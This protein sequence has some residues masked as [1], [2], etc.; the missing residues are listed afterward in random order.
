MTLKNLFNTLPILQQVQVYKEFYNKFNYLQ[1][2]ETKSV[3]KG[4]VTNFK[5]IVNFTVIKI[6]VENNVLIVFVR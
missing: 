3:Y 1:K 6:M 5:H 4:N 2:N